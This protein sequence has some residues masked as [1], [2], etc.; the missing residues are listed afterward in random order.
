MKTFGPAYRLKL[1]KIPNRSRYIK[2]NYYLNQSETD[3]LN[4]IHLGLAL[5]NFLEANGEFKKSFF[6]FEKIQLKVQKKL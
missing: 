5:S 1:V 4:D 6:L 2:I 3:E